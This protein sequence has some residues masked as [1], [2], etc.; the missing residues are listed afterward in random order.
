M[1]IITLTTDYGSSDYYVGALKGVILQLAPKAQII[2]ITHDI[3]AHDV[4]HG[5]FVLR[6]LWPWYPEGT[7]HLA[8]VD[9]G[10][11]TSRRILAARF[12]G[13][14]LVAPDNG[15]LT[16]L[17]REVRTEAIHVVDNPRYFLHPPSTTFHGRDL[18]APVAAHLAQG[19]K[20][21]E[22]GRATH[23]V[24][25]LP[26]PARPA[27]SA[28]GLSGQVIYVDRF[29]NLV[30]NITRASLLALGAHSGE[31]QVTVNDTELG[32]IQ[33]AFGQVPVGTPVGLIG[34]T[35][36]VEIAVNQGRAIDHFGPR[37]RI[38]VLVH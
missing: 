8:V 23:R 33:E 1:P 12:D 29:G 34:S 10:V 2:D 11:G 21:R 37:D 14:F 22:F 5:A 30:T 36:H 6:A 17:H 16:F 18:M 27:V 4:L 32:P 3:G 13:Q 38:R 35:E 26:V 25:V 19:V 31:F 15:L 20:L 28:A 7:V 24:E 9:P